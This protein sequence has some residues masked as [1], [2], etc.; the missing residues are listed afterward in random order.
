M[1][2][3]EIR[4]RYRQQR[5]EVIREIIAKEISGPLIREY[6]TD[7][8]KIMVKPEDQAS[9][10]EDVMEDLAEID[11]NRIAGL[12]ITPEQLNRWLDKNR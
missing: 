7:Q 4:V 12:G 3:D 9:F 6:V 10:S 8:T 5:R 1:G 2:F 11:L